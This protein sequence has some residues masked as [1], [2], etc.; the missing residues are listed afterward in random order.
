MAN[1]RHMT[2]SKVT[3]SLQESW[4]CELGNFELLD[5]FTF[6]S[7]L[8]VQIFPFQAILLE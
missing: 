4:P 6:L 2:V 7:A 5:S 1:L 8:W 3:Q